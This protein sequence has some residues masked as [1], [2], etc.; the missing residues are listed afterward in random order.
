LTSPIKAAPIPD[1]SPLDQNVDFPPTIFDG[2]DRDDI[3]KWA[4][5]RDRPFRGEKEGHLLPGNF[6]LEYVLW[7]RKILAE[8]LASQRTSATGL[9]EK[10]F[11]ETRR[12]IPK[13][14]PYWEKGEAVSAEP[15]PDVSFYFAMARGQCF[16]RYIG[17]GLLPIS[18][19][20]I[21]EILKSQGDRPESLSVPEYLATLHRARKILPPTYV[22]AKTRPE[23]QLT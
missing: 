2:L 10:F 18:E 23:F 6:S 5:S 4:V 17:K 21:A 13:T 7:I 22:I 11:N 12:L 9:L 14:D 3:E 1:A 15:D 8:K 16:W 20:E 19:E